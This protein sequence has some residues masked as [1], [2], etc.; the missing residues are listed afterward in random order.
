MLHKARLWRRRSVSAG[1]D[2][3]EILDEDQESSKEIVNRVVALA[4][5]TTLAL[6]V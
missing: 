1:E 4:L 5:P 3:H 6:A 2:P